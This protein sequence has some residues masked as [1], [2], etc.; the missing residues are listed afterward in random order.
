VSVYQHPESRF[1][2][3][4]FRLRGRRYRGSTG[5]SDR[6][7]AE[8]FERRLRTELEDALPTAAGPR[9]TL[10][11][12]GELDE[13]RAKAEGSSAAQVAAIAGHWRCLHAILGDD[14]GP[15]AVTYDV[16]EEYVAARRAAGAKGQTI[17]R[18]VQALRRGL[19]VA[20]RRKAIRSIPSEWPKIRR[21]PPNEKRRGHLHDVEVLRKYIAA[22][23]VEPRA[24]VVVALLTGL[25]A[26]E[27]RRLTWA[28]V[29]EAPAGV[30][31]PALLRVPAAGS[32]TKTERVVALPG[33]AL[34]ALQ[35]IHERVDQEDEE[36]LPLLAS[37]W[38]KQYAKASA[39]IKY[40]RP[41]TLRD[42]RHCY[43]TIGLQA[44]GDA[45]AAQAALGHT[46]LAVTQR[47]QTATLRRAA[48]VGV[49]VADAL[50][51][52]SASN[53][54]SE[55]ATGESTIGKPALEVGRVGLE[56]TTLGLKDLLECIR[57]ELGADPQ[58]W[59]DVLERAAAQLDG[60]QWPQGRPQVRSA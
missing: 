36:P 10:R 8:S 54:H 39:A 33:P 51:P 56:P 1:W 24:Q 19:K 48:S 37:D 7:R 38:R 27:L 14:P 25:R 53:G 12:L 28:W 29:E 23:P 59:A 60:W 31:V 32:K 9:L 18:E 46:Q 49:A 47:Y 17:V 6:R 2:W 44:T 26:A 20:V 35:A 13:A 42:L 16:V 4:C 50:T 43:G 55:V 45:A 34:E 58:A 3:Y 11:R 30:G 52:P 5:E 15:G 41:I 40:K 22:L 21:D 57:L